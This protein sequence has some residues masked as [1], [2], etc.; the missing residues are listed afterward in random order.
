MA[1]GIGEYEIEEMGVRKVLEC[2]TTFEK[3]KAM[4]H[5]LK[6]GIIHFFREKMDYFEPFMDIQSRYMHSLGSNGAIEISRNLIRLI[7]QYYS[8]NRRQDFDF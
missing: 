4:H 6:D 7:G 1:T 2:I 5:K 3:D 8:R